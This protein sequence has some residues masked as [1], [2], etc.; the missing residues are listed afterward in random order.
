MSTK[1]GVYLGI[2]RYNKGD[3]SAYASEYSINEMV[4]EISGCVGFET[5]KLANSMIELGDL[6]DIEALIKQRHDELVENER[7]RHEE[8]MQELA[9]LSAA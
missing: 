8:R 9:K 3:I 4:G 2:G 5:V 6:P 1:I 7:K